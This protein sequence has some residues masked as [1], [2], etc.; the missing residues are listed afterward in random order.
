MDKTQ[1]VRCIL[2]PLLNDVLLVPHS[3][4]AEI[5]AYQKVHRVADSPQ[6]LL[7]VIDW[8]GNDVPL[9]SFEAAIGGE[10]GEVPPK[11][12]FVVFTA[13]GAATQG[14]LYAVRIKGIP[15]FE[16]IDD[17]SISAA[18]VSSR[19]NP[20]IASRVIVNGVAACIPDI[21]ALES[22]VLT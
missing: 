3:L 21:D 4:V 1:S 22:M 5:V 17:T 6:W 14:K 12:Q 20:L 11:V 10:V 9:L 7:G 18:N 13:I 19:A 8:K 2:L 16:T 15:H